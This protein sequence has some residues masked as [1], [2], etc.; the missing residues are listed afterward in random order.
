MAHW[1]AW[2][3]VI[4][5]LTFNISDSLGIFAAEFKCMHV[6]L[7]PIHIGVALRLLFWPIFLFI[8]FERPP[9]WLFGADWFKMLV[10]ISFAF[11]QGYFTEICAHKAPTY[12]KE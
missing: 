8:I 4:L 7:I 12:V 11:T 5:V 10:L 6:S 9:T 3:S 2:W 1:D